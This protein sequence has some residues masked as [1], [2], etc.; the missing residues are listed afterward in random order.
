MAEQ[1][2]A[3][4]EQAIDALT[5]ALADPELYTTNA[6]AASATRLGSELDAAKAALERALNVW[7]T[8]TEAAEALSASPN[9]PT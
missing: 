1:E 2:V 9:A 4:I 5:R 7:T 3:R 6:G 8:A